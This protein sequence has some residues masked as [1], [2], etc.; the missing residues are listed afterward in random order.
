MITRRNDPITFSINSVFPSQAGQIHNSSNCRPKVVIH[1]F[2]RQIGV[3]D[4][5][6]VNVLSA[7]QNG[8][9][10]SHVLTAAFDE[11]CYGGGGGGCRGRVIKVQSTR[12][13]GWRGYGGGCWWSWRCQMT[14]PAIESYFASASN[15]RIRR[16]FRRSS[17]K[18]RR[19]HFVGGKPDVVKSPAHA[20]AGRWTATSARV[21]VIF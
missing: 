10:E 21:L 1:V 15:L 2:I 4:L 7:N 9:F 6:D 12:Y 20:S 16:N 13:Y 8:R 18:Y 19:R 14:M 3:N 11:W 5:P 17:G